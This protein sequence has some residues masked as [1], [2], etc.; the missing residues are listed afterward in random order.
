MMREKDERLKKKEEEGRRR[1]MT[2]I[3]GLR[4]SKDQSEKKKDDLRI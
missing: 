1:R 4:R 2:R 3:E